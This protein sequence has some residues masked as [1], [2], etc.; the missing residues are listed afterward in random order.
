MRLQ[1]LVTKHLL[2]DHQ[3]WDALLMQ[4]T[5]VISAKKSSPTSTG[6]ETHVVLEIEIV[7]EMC[8]SMGNAHGGFVATLADNTTTMAA[9]PLSE[10][11]FWDFGGVSRT[12]NVTYL[13]PM[14]KGCIVVSENWVRSAGKKL[15][16]SKVLR[17]RVDVLILLP[18]CYTMYHEGQAEWEDPRIGRA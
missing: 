11:G 7:P 13:R 3:G 1:T 16:K 4:K 15:C 8:N 10:T 18:S 9:A 17:L 2:I 12:L 14:P 6:A 5:K